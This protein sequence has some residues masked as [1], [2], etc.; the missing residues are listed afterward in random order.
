ME[1]FPIVPAEDEGRLN[2]P[3]LRENFIERVFVFNRWRQFIK[4]GGG[5]RDLVDFH[6]DHKL[7]VL[8]HSPKHYTVLGRYVAGSKGYAGRLNDVYIESLM[9]GLRLI[10]TTKKNTNVLQHIMGYFKK[11][12]I[13]DEK[14]ELLD[15]IENYYKGLIP[16]IVPIAL[17]QHYV[18]KYDQPYLKQQHYLHPHP[19]ELKLRN[20]A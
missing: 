8:A 4:K 12:L 9:E 7:L 3:A 18:R 17:L 11:N 6:R 19:M 20:H 1:K 5:T 13:P 2:D 15:V 10:A 16:L 14:Q